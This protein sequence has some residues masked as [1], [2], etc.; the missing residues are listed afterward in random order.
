MGNLT[1]NETHVGG[2]WQST[3]TLVSDHYLENYFKRN[4][5][6]HNYMCVGF[7]P[8]TSFFLWKCHCLSLEWGKNQLTLLNFLNAG[9]GFWRTCSS[10]R[11]FTSIKIA[12]CMAGGVL[13]TLWGPNWWGIWQPS[14]NIFREQVIRKA[15]TVWWYRHP[16]PSECPKDASF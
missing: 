7:V 15:E 13:D 8:S 9:K 1:R 11:H 14:Q 3:K 4:C 5:P 2:I 6:R 12:S 10:L 16:G